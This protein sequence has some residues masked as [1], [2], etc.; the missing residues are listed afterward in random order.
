MRLLTRSSAFFL[1]CS[2]FLFAACQPSSTGEAVPVEAETMDRGMLIGLSRV[3]ITPENPIRLSGYGNRR[4]P[5]EGVDGKLW[6]KAMA[7]GRGEET[8][9]LVTLDLIGV[10]EWLTERVAEELSISAS[11][12]ALC[13]THT[14]S[15]PH[16]RNVLDPIFMEDIPANHWSVIEDYSND[17]T[18]KVVQ[19]CRL[20]LENRQSGNLEWGQGMVSFAGNRRVLEKGKWAGFGNQPDGP[21]DHALPVLKVSNSKGKL[22]AILANYACHCTTLGGRY[23]KVHGDWAGEAQRLLE[24]RHPGINAMI[25]IGCGADANPVPRGEMKHVL[26]HGKSLADEVDR[27]LATRLTP[28]TSTPKTT[29]DRIDLPLDPLPSREY[30]EE[31]AASRQR[32][33]WYGK[34]ILARLDGGE[35]LPASI[36]YPIQ[37]WTFGNDLAMVFLPGEVVVDYSLKLKEIFHAD[38]IWINAYAN[39][40]PSYIP[41]RRLYDEGGYEVDGSMYYYDKP[42]RLSPDTEDLVLDEVLQQLPHTFYSA[43]TLERIPAPIAKEKALATM[44]VHPDLEIELVAAE[45]MVMDP[46]DI[47]WG[48]DGRMW[49]VEMADYPLGMDG[50]GKG[51]GRIRYLEDTN[52]DGKY[53]EST[54]FLEA[55]YPTSVFPWKN[56]VLVTTAPDLIYAE[57]TNFDGKADD[58][59]ILY[60][61]F[62]LGNQQHLVNGMQWGPD[63]KI[64]LANG[65]SGGIVRSVKTGKTVDIDGRDLRIDPGNGSIEAINGGT[66]FGRNRDSW[67][68]WFGNSNSWPGWHFALD[69]RYLQRNPHV[70]YTSARV[71]LPQVPTAGPVYPISKT[72]SRFNDYEKAN[73]FTSACGYMIYEDSVLGPDFVGNSFIAEPVHNLVSRAIVYPEGA[74]FRSKRAPEEMESEFLRSTDNWFRPTAIRSGPDGA[75]YVVDMYRFAIEHPEWIPEDWQR[76]INLREGHDKGRIYRIAKKGTKRLP[77][78]DLTRLSTSELSETLHSEIRWLRDQAFQMLRLRDDAE[79][80]STLSRAVESASQ[81]ETRVLA[82]W[83]LDDMDA[84]NQ[85]TLLRGLNDEVANVRAQ[86]VKFAEGFL[87]NEVILAKV[88]QLA[89]D[90]S[91]HVRKQVAYTLGESESKIAGNALFELIQRDHEDPILLSAALSSVQPHQSKLAELA[92]S[93]LLQPR[94]GKFLDGLLNTALGSKN[95]TVLSVLVSA[96]LNQTGE[97][98]LPDH[99]V[100][101]HAYEKAA[102]RFSEDGE[103]FIGSN[104]GLAQK[105]TELFQAARILAMDSQLPVADRVSALSILP[106]RKK[107]KEENIA[108]ARELL[109]PSQSMELQLAAVDSLSR[110]L[111]SQAPEH[112]L[113]YWESVGPRIRAKIL[114]ILLSRKNWTTSLLRKASNRPE[115]ISSFSAVQRNRLSRSSD[116]TI[117]TLAAALFGNRDTSNRQQLVDDYRAALD[118]VGDPTSGSA[119]FAS[120]CA[121][122]HHMEGVGVDVGPN[123]SSLSDKSPQALLI[124]ILDPNRA[125][126]DKFKQYIVT[127]KNGQTSTG[128][129]SEETST[130][131]TLTNIGGT[132]QTLLRQNLSSIKSTDLSLMPEGLD[133]GLDHRQMADLLAYLNASDESLKIRPKENGEVALSASRGIVSGSSAYYNPDTSAIEW[134][135]AGDSIEWTVYDLSPGFYDVFTDAGLGKEYKGRPFKL[136]LNDTFTTGAVVYSRSMHN[137]RKRK[138]GNILVHAETPKAVFRLEHSLPDAEFGLKE[139]R[140]IPVK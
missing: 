140:L 116:P 23:N 131:I 119:H 90:E 47:A 120:L 93:R 133:A 139:I 9:L 52:R 49:V 74:S 72:L 53:D 66:Q 83:I 130:T 50:K 78:P 58:V 127:A 79:V 134:I 106:Y 1:L 101:Y 104:P 117:K 38:R 44:E 88:S 57:D 124:A 26:A 85:E 22:R 37:T 70:A 97:H 96:I 46:I 100:A 13:A 86:A 17:L 136:F 94:L 73:R 102:H 39:A 71:F 56:G 40:S 103:G 112:L 69:D 132:T 111:Q 95:H 11:N 10:P 84:L 64:Y 76:K 7:L 34:K 129:L 8:V 54:V 45:P 62:N 30:W 6:A 118:L 114:D 36:G 12:L 16:L 43:E 51:G 19:A 25:A 55:S 15:G 123:L 20:A 31:L 5:S 24:E 28:L 2:S 92:G 35:S 80:A 113:N 135:G 138:F 126:E 128:I 41:S 61:G 14:H 75:L 32:T 4:E 77:T 65:D 110:I 125:V 121:T 18:G 91:A 122:C 3:D 82:F 59:E 42:I 108:L 63:A 109:N 33:A 48:P 99:L 21:V 27:L 137:Y 107:G 89:H 115:I 68:N 60:T 105:R 67:G 81:P 29:L 87:D 98:S